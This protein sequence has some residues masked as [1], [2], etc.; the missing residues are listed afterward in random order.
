VY[1]NRIWGTRG[2]NQKVP[3]VRKARTSEDSMGM[4]MALAEIPKK[5]GRITCQDHVQRLGMALQLRD[6]TTH[7]YPKF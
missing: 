1:S 4:R 7:P 6:G 5:T 2:S 3:D